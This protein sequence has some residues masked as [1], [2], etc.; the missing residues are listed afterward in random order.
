MPKAHS[1]LLAAL[2]KRNVGL[3]CE[4]P[5]F[6]VLNAFRLGSGDRIASDG[7]TWREGRVSVSGP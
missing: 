3:E 7:A 6:H 4:G 2:E 5:G 1:V